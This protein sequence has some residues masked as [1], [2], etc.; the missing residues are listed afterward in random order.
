MNA[1][2]VGLAFIVGFAGGYLLQ[3]NMTKQVFTPEQ[4]LKEVKHKIKDSLQLDGAW[5]YQHTEEWQGNR[6]KQFVYRG[7]I[8]EKTGDTLQHYDFIVDSETGT[9]L[10]LTPQF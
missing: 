6:V 1:K 3:K 9:L 10:S 4:A 2:N 8:T 5:I 7:G